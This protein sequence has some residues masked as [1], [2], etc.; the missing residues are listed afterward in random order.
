MTMHVRQQILAAIQTALTGLTTTGSNVF[1]SRVSTI[2]RT[3]VPCIVLKAGFEQQEG[4]DMGAPRM[5]TRNLTVELNVIVRPS[6]GLLDAALNQVFAEVEVA[7]AMPNSLAGMK[8]ITLRSITEPQEVQGEQEMAAAT[9][10][11]EVVYVTQENAP[12][13]AH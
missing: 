13:V 11:Y 4:D 9:M 5:L 8:T 2:A 10:R 1:L 6:D 3:E 12:T 7:L